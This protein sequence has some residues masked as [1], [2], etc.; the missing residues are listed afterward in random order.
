[1][2]L[3]MRNPANV[4]QQRDAEVTAPALGVKLVTAD[5]RSAAEMDAAFQ[6]FAR[7]RTQF[8]LVLSDLIF[9]TERRRIAALAI[10]ARL[11]TIYGLRE[12][13]ED[14]G[15]VT[16]GVSLVENWRRA[17]YFVDKILQGTKPADLPV[18]LPTKFE[19]VINLKTAKALGVDVPDKLLALADEVI[20]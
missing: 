15:L 16:Y 12:H 10:A 18:E 4:S 17:A 7:E 2:L 9:T 8:V 3:N 14:G 20:E 13:A 5:V 11:P 1:M 19:L 6:T